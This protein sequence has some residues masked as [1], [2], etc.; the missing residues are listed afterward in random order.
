MDSDI[1]VTV[2]IPVYNAGRYLKNAV[3]SV[4]SQTYKNLEILITIDGATDNSIDIIKNYKDKR[5]RLIADNENKGVAYRLNQQVKMA[6]GSFFARMDADDIMFPDRIEKQLKFMI[7]NP[8]VDVIG[9]QAVVIDRDN[10][11]LGFRQSDT[12]ISSS[13]IQ[14]KILFIHPTV[15]GRTNWFLKHSYLTELDG[16]E[17]FYLWNS[18]FSE[19]RFH[20]LNFPLMFYRDPP[21]ANVNSYLRRQKQMRRA[22]IM[23]LQ[24]NVMNSLAFCRLYMASFL[25]SIIYF[26]SGRMNLSQRIVSGRNKQLPDSDLAE[27]SDLMKKTTLEETS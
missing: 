11:I 12:T 19:S 9:S 24:E 27:Y 5:I 17:D 1:M 25:K 15:F 23:L 20:V 26:L 13:L 21:D 14:N 10:S 22:L 18:T 6:E 3:D 2:G 16:V 7:A 8:D 4:L